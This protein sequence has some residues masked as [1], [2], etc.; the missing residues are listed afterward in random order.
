MEAFSFFKKPGRLSFQERWW[1]LAVFF[2]TYLCYILTL[3]P[4]VT[5][6]DSGE[7]STSVAT[8]GISHPPGYPLYNILGKIFTLLVPFGNFAW[9][10]NLFSAFCGALAAGLLYLCFKLL[11]RND[12]LSATGAVLFAA[13]TIFWSQAI[14]A[15]VY[16]L[17]TALFLLILFLLLL[18][19]EKLHEFSQKE[20]Q[21]FLWFAA[22]LYGLSLGDHYMMFLAAIPFLL[23]VIL[24][25][26]KFFLDWKFLLK[27]CVFFACGLAV[28]LY[29]P[30]R[31]S[32]NPALNWGNPSNW[33]NFW[34]HVT[35]KLYSSGAVDPSIHLQPAVQQQGPPFFSSWWF[36][37]VARYHVWQ[38]FL[39]VM[40]HFIEDYFWGLL[41]FVPSGF[42]WLLKK[43]K[44]HFWMFLS[45]FVFYGFVFSYLIGLGWADK[46]PVELFKDRPFFIPVLTVLFFVSLLGIYDVAKTFSKSLPIPKIFG[47]L[48]A[49]LLIF[50]V[51]AHFKS[52]NQSRN[53]VA[54]DLARLALSILPQHA[55]YFIQNSDNTLFPILYLNKVEGLRQDINFYIPSPINVYNFFTTLD[56]LEQQNPGRRVFTDFPFT[57]YQGGAYNY[58][59]PVSEIVPSQN[60]SVQ[61]DL[62]PLLEAVKIRGFDALNL[63]HF[64]TYLHGRYFLDLGLVYGG[65]DDKKQQDLFN[66]AVST[67]QDSVN[68]FSQLIGNYDVRRSLFTQ[69]LPFLDKAHG[70]YPDEYSINFELLLCHIM[71]GDPQGAVPYFVTLVK[72]DQN[73]FLQDYQQ[74]K[75]MFAQD[76]SKFA[77]FEKLLQQEAK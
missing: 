48:L 24:S 22:F 65:I 14:R 1:S 23:F 73:Q 47:G 67:A 42:W 40:Q 26:P 17:N 50:N 54:Y 68:I 28:Y 19:R 58:F 12:F 35:R 30:I 31:A 7:F 51:S 56:G 9:R 43:S 44:A 27:A 25:A 3:Y 61:E 36:D 37:E 63:D 38:M 59:G 4:T 53:Y 20:S 46:I 32:M 34:D 8:L 72:S 45:L 39:Y 74:L 15:E 77:S 57:D 64:N 60:L 16:T 33:Q 10:V 13:G 6:E 49:L 21:R 5:T 55:V 62:L 69:A 76:A 52:E 29:L 75:G 11:T 18:W 71:T 66:K 70:F 41:F 2:V